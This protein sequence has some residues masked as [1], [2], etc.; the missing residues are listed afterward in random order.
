VG[1]NALYAACIARAAELLGG[2]EALAKRLGIP[3][4]VLLRWSH[5]KEGIPEPV[6]LEVVDVLLAP[7]GRG[8]GDL[9]QVVHQPGDG[10]RKGE[11]GDEDADASRHPP[12]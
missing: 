10:V 4:Q 9:D 11:R 5:G 12:R 7:L 8:Q 3:A 1:S 2:Y 6:F